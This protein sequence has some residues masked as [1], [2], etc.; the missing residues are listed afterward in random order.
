MTRPGLCDCSDDVR[1]YT[2]SNRPAAVAAGIA[3]ILQLSMVWSKVCG[4]YCPSQYK[5][6]LSGHCPPAKWLSGTGRNVGPVLYSIRPLWLQLSSKCVLHWI[7]N[8]CSIGIQF[9]SGQTFNTSKKGGGLKHEAAVFL[10]FNLF[11]WTVVIGPLRQTLP[12]SSWY[13]SEGKTNNKSPHSSLLSSQVGWP[14]SVHQ[15]SKRTFHWSLIFI[16]HKAVQLTL[17]YPSP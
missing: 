9:P 1:L 5:S 4:T 6:H 13:F 10:V 17:S 12:Y 2:F 7:C 15:E 3:K 14:I 8:L 16:R 11:F